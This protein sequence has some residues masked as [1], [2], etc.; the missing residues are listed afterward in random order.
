MLVGQFPNTA[1]VVD[2]HG[3]GHILFYRIIIFIIV[4]VLFLIANI[5]FILLDIIVSIKGINFA[6]WFI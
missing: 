3:D 5:C 2:H 1:N 6:H 4:L